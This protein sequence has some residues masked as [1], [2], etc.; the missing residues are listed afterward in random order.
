M[1]QF[2]LNESLSEVRQAGGDKKGGEF[3]NVGDKICPPCTVC[4]N[5]FYAD[6]SSQ[7]QLQQYKS[8]LKSVL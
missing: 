8:C 3:Q 2:F 4:S 7:R 5:G 1:T 6:I